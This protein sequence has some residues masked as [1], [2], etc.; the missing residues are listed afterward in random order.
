MVASDSIADSKLKPVTEPIDESTLDA[1]KAV[2]S[3]SE[4]SFGVVTEVLAKES[5]SAAQESTSDSASGSENVAC[6]DVEH[7]VESSIEVQ[8]VMA[9]DVKSSLDTTTEQSMKPTNDDTISKPS[10]DPLAVA[11]VAADLVSVSLTNVVTELSLEPTRRTEV[12]FSGDP[13]TGV[14]IDTN[15][16]QINGP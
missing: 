3:E 11:D 5:L 4:G 2:G 9:S 12:E 16:T 14:E 7:V 10:P 1:H 8:A 15:T 6:S 13:N